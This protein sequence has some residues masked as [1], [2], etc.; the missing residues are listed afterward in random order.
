MW[1]YVSGLHFCDRVDRPARFLSYIR[2]TL[3]IFVVLCLS[4]IFSCLLQ[5]DSGG[6]L[7]HLDSDGVYTLV[8]I[9]SFGSNAGCQ[10]G[11]PAA[12]TRVTSYLN[13]IQSTTGIAISWLMPVLKKQNWNATHVNIPLSINHCI[14]S[15][16]NYENCG[17][18]F[19][20]AKIWYSVLRYNVSERVIIAVTLMI[21]ILQV[22]GTPINLI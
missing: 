22:L 11:Y 2:T 9:T 21:F 20:E 6:P 18:Y 8:G 17:F 16:T 4:L 7:V 3:A 1:S 14:N 15:S 19:Y 13:W 10:K 5:G 12:F